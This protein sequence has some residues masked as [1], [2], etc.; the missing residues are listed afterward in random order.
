[1]HRLLAATLLLTAAAAHAQLPIKVDGADRPDQIPDNIAYAH[2]VILMAQSDEPSTDELARG[3]GALKK[4]DLAAADTTRFKAALAG[5]HKELEFLTR[6]EARLSAAKA[7]PARIDRLRL[8]RSRVF[9]EATTRLKRLS[10]AGRA[11]LEAFIEAEIK[12]NVV[13]YGE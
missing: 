1:V 7:E 6:E 3:Q 8:Q 2:F 13:I 9:D 10:P 5:V 11:K 4:L 12:P